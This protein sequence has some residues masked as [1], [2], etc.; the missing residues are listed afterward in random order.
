MV[1]GMDVAGDAP[2]SPEDNER[3]KEMVHV[4]FLTN[5]K[6]YPIKSPILRSIRLF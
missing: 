1:V 6:D 2:G 4:T 3:I 5:F